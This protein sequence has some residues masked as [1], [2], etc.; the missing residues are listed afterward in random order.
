MAVT[1]A[2][3]LSDAASNWSDPATKI[4]SLRPCLSTKV[5]PAHQDDSVDAVRR[6]AAQRIKVALGAAA[7]AESCTTTP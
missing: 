6:I 1:S 3:G 7:A 4:R 5:A 2:A